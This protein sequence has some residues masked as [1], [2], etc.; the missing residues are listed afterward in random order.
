VAALRELFANGWQLMDCGILDYQIWICVIIFCGSHW[1][2]KFMWT[3][4]ILWKIEGW[5]WKRDC[6]YLKT[7]T[8]SCVKKYIQQVQGLRTSS[9]RSWRQTLWDTWMK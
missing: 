2:M 1:K 5:Y 8:L 6:Q 4:H 9:S 3:V 7:R